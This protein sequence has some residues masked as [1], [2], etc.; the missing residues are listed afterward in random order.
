MNPRRLF[1]AMLAAVC[2]ALTALFVAA[3]WWLTNNLEMADERFWGLIML[4]FLS[5]FSEQPQALDQS[6]RELALSLRNHLADPVMVA[7]SQLSRWPV[8]L[9][10]AL[11]LLLWLVGAGRTKAAVHWL[12]AI[13]GGSLLHLL[14]SWS[15][16]TTPEV[17]EL[18][19]R[20]LSSPSAAMSLTTVVLFFFAV[21]EAG[22]LPRRHRQW[23]YLAAGLLVLL[24]GTA[25]I[26]LGLEWLSGALMGIL[27]GLAWTAV[28]VAKVTT[29]SATSAAT[30]TPT[31]WRRMKRPAR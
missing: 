16:R 18:D 3:G 21:M 22:E 19:E 2:A 24:L 15:L 10:A 25:R 14:L 8:P 17:L 29:R 4:L 20:L 26:Y 13:G 11:A 30:A 28:A 27:A 6:V 5:P 9:L 12:I 31:R 23:P 7:L 1:W